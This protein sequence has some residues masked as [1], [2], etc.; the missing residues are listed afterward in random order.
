MAVAADG[1]ALW[2]GDTNSYGADSDDAFLLHMSPNAKAI[3]GDTWGGPGI[4][5]DDGVDAAQDGT[6]SLGAPLRRHRSRS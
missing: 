3:D 1:T 4:D 2:S 6:I 5:H